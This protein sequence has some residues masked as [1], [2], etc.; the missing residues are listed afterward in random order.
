[1]N[2]LR[3]ILQDE[4]VKCCKC[5]WNEG[6]NT[7]VILWWKLGNSKMLLED[8]KDPLNDTVS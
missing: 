2:L 6:L 1:V 8:P 4:V 7:H 3:V 5:R